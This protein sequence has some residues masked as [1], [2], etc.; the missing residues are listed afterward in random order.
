MSYMSQLDWQC[1]EAQAI[2]T[3]FMA[4]RREFDE[5]A[6]MALEQFTFKA[7]PIEAWELTIPYMLT[8][9]FEEWG[10]LKVTLQ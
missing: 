4:D 9:A 1:L 8:W 2:F 3:D 6:I 7:T 10:E 5:L